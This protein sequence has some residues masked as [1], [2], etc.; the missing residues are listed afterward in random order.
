M[1]PIQACLSIIENE[2]E[3]VI[4]SGT[5]SSVIRRDQ[6]EED[7]Q[8]S[9]HYPGLGERQNPSRFSFENSVGRETG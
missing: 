8:T 3:A 5:A 9:G 7:Y 4:K 6:G 2:N 1:R